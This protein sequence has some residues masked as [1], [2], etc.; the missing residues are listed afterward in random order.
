MLGY[1]SPIGS[2]E[3]GQVPQQPVYELGYTS[4]PFVPNGGVSPGPGQLRLDPTCPEY[5]IMR[6]TLP[7]WDPVRRSSVEGKN[8]FSRQ[9][10]ALMKLSLLWTMPWALIGVILAVATWH[11]QSDP[12]R[13][14]VG[15]RG[16][17]AM[18]AFM[19]GTVG[20]ISGIAAGLTLARA[21][22]GKAIST[23]SARRTYLWGAAGGLIPL[24]LFGASVA[25]FGE[26][27]VALLPSFALAICSALLSGGVAASALVASRHG[28]STCQFAR[29]PLQLESQGPSEPEC[30]RSSSESPP[31]TWAVHN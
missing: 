15:V 13:L 29:E 27:T 7:F 1:V 3:Q 12:V 30:Q 9:F 24:G 23:M 6:E 31:K 10:R 8:M 20:A 21:E 4:M 26:F 16:W 5:R 28:E 18:H 25:I 22:R 2:E 19:Y 14:Y 11:S 17:L